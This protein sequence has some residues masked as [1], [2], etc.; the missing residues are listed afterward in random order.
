MAKRMLIDATHAEETRV[1]VVD[2]K[3]V[4][5][6]DFEIGGRQQL[7][8]NIYLAKVTRVEPALQA[9]FIEYGGNRHG[10]L[11]FPE[12]HPD[13]Y[14]IPLADREAIIEEELAYAEAVRLR[15]EEE[16][17]E[18]QN[19]T[20]TSQESRK[21]DRSRGRKRVAK[22]KTAE[23]YTVL[24]DSDDNSDPLP[25]I[26]GEDVN[27]QHSDDEASVA[28]LVT[29]SESGPD[30]E[31]PIELVGERDDL[32]DIIV[33]PKS[34]PRRYNIQ[35]VIKVR[36]ILLV[37]VVKEERGNKGVALTTYIS[38][39]GRFCVLMPNTAR[40]GGISRKISNAKDRMKLK[41]IAASFDVP[42]GAGLIVR[43]AGA[44][45]TKAEIKRDY[46]YLQRLWEE[47]RSLTLK[48]IAPALIYEEGDL[49]KRSIR[50]LY[51]REISEVLVEGEGGYRAAKDFMKMIMPS[52]ARHV[53]KYEEKTRLFARYQIESYLA[54]MFNP[55][56]ELRSGGYIVIASTEA[57]VAIDVNSG[58]STRQGSVEDTALRTNL[59]AAEEIARQLRLRDL[60]G[61]I[62]IDFIDMEKR[63]N[64]SAVERR[65]REGLQTDRARLQ[66]GRISPFGLLEMSRQRLR[67]ALIEKTTQICSHCNGT[68]R[69]RSDDSMALS[70]LRQLEELISRR[71]AA[72]LQIQCSVPVANFLMNEKRDHIVEIEN[73]HN[74]EIRLQADMAQ[75]NQDFS[76]QILRT[77]KAEGSANNLTVVSGSSSLMNEVDQKEEVQKGDGAHIE[78][79]ENRSPR[80]RR[81]RGR[82]RRSSSAKMDNV[83]ETEVR[84][85]TEG[86][87][88]SEDTEKPDN[89]I[90]AATEAP[91][92]APKKPSRKRRK[93]AS[94][95]DE[96]ASVARQEDTPPQPNALPGDAVDT[97]TELVTESA[98]KTRKPRRKGNSRARPR[99][100]NE[101]TDV[102]PSDLPTNILPSNEAEA[103]L[104]VEEMQGSENKRRG[105]W[106]EK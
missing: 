106:S 21:K 86:T 10:F 101:E 25:I 97:A 77:T 94:K 36:Q 32:E 8:G 22:K 7:T 53:K 73:R 38:L 62:V 100:A 34:R 66:I 13:Y 35:E 29:D 90:Q 85:V 33:P 16:R 78:G 12:I 44:N 61:L 48:S 74:L 47:I 59:E 42:K 52:H 60:S 92:V 51:S 4:E 103:S 20:E 49:I 50:D 40:G 64:N 43:T 1:A 56:A 37:Q 68:G 65:L 99:K 72:V 98:L 27:N 31:S 81:R 9:A 30:K 5:E 80:R 63:S 17:G 57:L 19:V 82:R 105:W 71:S 41:G 26:G 11:T 54:E 88:V 28:Q 3:R 75:N 45:R 15:E 69:V 95:K 70:I 93:S 39:A 2:G 14:Q 67:P 102:L 104:K 96:K 18:A 24:S 89:G 46:D 58:R 6:F 55:T 87:E 76:L 23:T 84:A 83:S 91:T 79:N